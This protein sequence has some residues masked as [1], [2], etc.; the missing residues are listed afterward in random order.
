MPYGEVLRRP[1]A[2]V[3]AAVAVL[4]L[5][6]AFSLLHAD[7]RPATVARVD[8]VE[9][10]RDMF[11]ETLERFTV[12]GESLGSIALRQLISEALVVQAND[13]YGLG[14]DDAAVEAE[15]EAA[16]R[17]YGDQLPT[18]LAQAGLTEERFREEIRLSLIL[19]RLVTRGIEVTEEE[20]AAFYEEHKDSAFHVPESYYASQ[21][22]VASEQ[23]AEEILALLADGADFAELRAERS[24]DKGAWG[25]VTK[26]DPIPQNIA[27]AIFSLQ[28]GEVSEPISVGGGG[29]YLIRL[30]KI[31]PE[32][33]LSLD[34]VRDEIREHL[35]YSKAPSI[36][37]AV[38]Q[39]WEEADIQIEWPRYSDLAL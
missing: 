11:Y 24:L 38:A 6:G 26:S 4:L 33:Y 34:E 14:V 20:I 31:V 30:D 22:L 28:V 10:S 12:N 36:E 17:V 23:E 39:L 32:D 3:F 16:A 27:D 29:Y 2:K 18:L 13:R 8:G 35:I 37:E 1:S 21:I 25:P 9:I 15:Y 5:V 7:E 19:D